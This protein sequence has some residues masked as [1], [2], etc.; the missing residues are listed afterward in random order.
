M[1]LKPYTLILFSA[2]CLQCLSTD[3]SYASEDKRELVTDI[4][5]TS[6]SLET[7]KYEGA[8][9]HHCTAIMI[10]PKVGL[11]AAH[12]KDGGFEQNKSLG[13][14]YP[15]SSGLSTNAGNMTISTFNPY[16]GA[17][18]ALIKGENPSTAYTHYMRNVDIDVKGFNLSDL[19]GKKVYSIGYPIDKGGRKQYKTEGVITSTYNNQSM[20]TTLQSTGGQSGSGV[21]LKENDQLIGIISQ[22]NLNGTIVQ[23]INRRISDWISI[24]K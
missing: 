14:I 13:T 16:D 1:K 10:S 11:T 8:D 7:A 22:G 18:I 19:E 12:C 23:P 20:M 17:D 2:L 3:E 4:F 24:K 9:T 6:K 21:F 15:G 5:N